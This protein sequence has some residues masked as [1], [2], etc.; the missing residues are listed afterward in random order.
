MAKGLLSTNHITILVNDNNNSGHLF[1]TGIHPKTLIAQAIIIITLSLSEKHQNYFTLGYLQPMANYWHKPISTYINYNIAN[2]HP[3]Q[4]GRWSKQGKV[5]CPGSNTLAIAG[6]ELTTSVYESCAV[7]LDHTCPYCF[8]GNCISN[9]YRKCFV[10][11]L[12][13]IIIF[14]IEKKKYDN[15]FWRKLSK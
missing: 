6:L 13:I 10:P 7:L 4:T 8:K 9:R 3:M 11:Y 5:L 1:C 12:F 15:H 14:F 2:K